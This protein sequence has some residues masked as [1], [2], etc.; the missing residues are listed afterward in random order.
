MF[1]R[2]FSM[3]IVCLSYTPTRRQIL[4]SLPLLTDLSKDKYKITENENINKTLYFYNDVTE[5]TCLSLSNDLK[6]LSTDSNPIHLHIQS[7]GGELMPTFNVVDIIERSPTP[8]YTYIDGYAA[9]AATLISIAGHKRFMG[10]H[11]LML[12][13]EL[14]G[15]NEGTY[16]DLKEGI[17]NMNTFMDFAKEIYLDN[18]NI[19]SS[20]LSSILSYNNLWLNSSMC[21]KYGFVDQIL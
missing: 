5:E 9:S 18:S 21:L 4:S 19:N 7:L 17:M 15:G 11:S 3:F 20:E 13:H 14:S 16:K 12:L 10:K 2:I 1:G 6:E 8:I